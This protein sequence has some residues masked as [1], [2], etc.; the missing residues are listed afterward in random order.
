MHYRRLKY[1]QR[2]TTVNHEQYT[3]GG[4]KL[5]YELGINYNETSIFAFNL[6]GMILSCL[7]DPKVI[8]YN[9]RKTPVLL[10]H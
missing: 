6:V 1:H 10:S 4:L 3:S 2:S 5:E 8:R 7:L 9:I